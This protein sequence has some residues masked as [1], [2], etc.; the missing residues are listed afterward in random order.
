MPLRANT[1]GPKGRLSRFPK[2][3]IFKNWWQSMAVGNCLQLSTGS[4]WD[5]LQW[6]GGQGRYRVAA[7]P[8]LVLGAA[9][10]S[11]PGTGHRA[12]RLHGSAGG[13]RGG[14]VCAAVSCRS[15]SRRAH[16]CKLRLRAVSSK[17]CFRFAQTACSLPPFAAVTGWPLSYTWLRHVS[18]KGRLPIRR[19]ASHGLAHPARH[20]PA[21]ARAGKAPGETP[22]GA[23]RRMPKG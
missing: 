17:P 3:R 10:L 23:F 8:R 21:P 9:G 14:R 2:R 1:L 22:A 11:M 12:Q 5:V 20:T 7:V 19:F 18:D 16:L 4:G 13:G 6:K 15:L